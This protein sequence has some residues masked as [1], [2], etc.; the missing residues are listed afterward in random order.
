MMSVNVLSVTIL[1]V[2]MRS[3]IML[4]VIKLCHD[5]AM[6]SVVMLDVMAPIPAFNFDKTEN[7]YLTNVYRD[8]EFSYS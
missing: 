1:S 8:R 6:L 7:I 3:V 4:S 2:I 5:D